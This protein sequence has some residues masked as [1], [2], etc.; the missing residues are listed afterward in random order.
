M[1]SALAKIASWIQVCVRNE[2]TEERDSLQ[3]LYGASGVPGPYRQ[4]YRC[5]A[6]P[7]AAGSGHCAIHTGGQLIGEH[8]LA[9]IDIQMADLRVAACT[10]IAEHLLANVDI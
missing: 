6:N 2:T 1:R 8:L 10:L 9:N 7:S 4:R 3:S 5:G